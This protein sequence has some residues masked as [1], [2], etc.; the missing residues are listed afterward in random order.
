MCFYSMFYIKQICRKWHASTGRSVWYFAFAPT[1]TLQHT[2]CI[3]FLVDANGNF[4]I[5]LP[6]LNSQLVTDGEQYGNT[7]RWPCIT[8]GG[9]N[10][11]INYRLLLRGQTLERKQCSTSTW[12]RANRTLHFTY[13][14]PMVTVPTNDGG[15]RVTDIW[16]KSNA[17]SFMGKL[18]A[19]PS[20]RSWIPWAKAASPL[21]SMCFLRSTT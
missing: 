1:R 20:I 2:S 8:L 9:F 16:E 12:P 5:R 10:D 7:Y 3:F 19:P 15:V 17:I 18:F 6:N 13:S 14:S 11:S 21:L 4:P